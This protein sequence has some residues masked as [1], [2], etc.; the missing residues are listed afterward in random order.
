MVCLQQQVKW[1]RP[2]QRYV[3]FLVF[4]G[5]ESVS[6]KR[7]CFWHICLACNMWT[8]VDACMPAQGFSVHCLKMEVCVYCLL[9][10]VLYG[11][12]ECL[13]ITCSA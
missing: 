5:S 9:Y 2:R 10:G 11:E 3:Q 1:S 12:G 7:K 8:S 4:V 13:L 6:G